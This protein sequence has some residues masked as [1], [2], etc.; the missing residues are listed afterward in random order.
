[1]PHLCIT[2]DKLEDGSVDFKV[3]VSAKGDFVLFVLARAFVQLRIPPRDFMEAYGAALLS[4]IT[5]GSVP[6]G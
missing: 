3:D 6:E 5:D 1:M 2:A 4:G